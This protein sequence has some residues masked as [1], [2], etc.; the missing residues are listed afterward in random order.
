MKVLGT[1]MWTFCSGYRS[2]PLKNGYSENLELAS[3]LVYISVKQAGV[4][5]RA[6]CV[7]S[8]VTLRLLTL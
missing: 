7:T 8:C 6:Q 4:S 2:V 3:L 5:E 1:N